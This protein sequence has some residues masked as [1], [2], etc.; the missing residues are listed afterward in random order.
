MFTKKTQTK[1]LDTI[2]ASFT[3]VRDDLANYLVSMKKEKDTKE[4][5]IARLNAD[6]LVLDEQSIKTA[7][8]LQKVEELLGD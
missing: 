7:R 4:F 2:M 5:D 6:I 1:T 8:A 3:Q